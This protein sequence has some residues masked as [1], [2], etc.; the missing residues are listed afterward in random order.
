MISS[1][2]NIIY[3]ADIQISVR[4]DAS[5]ELYKVTQ[6]TLT[7]TFSGTTLEFI[8]LRTISNHTHCH[9]LI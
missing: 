2:T 3:G 4:L 1:Q 5:V 8:L 7:I 9:V 6:N